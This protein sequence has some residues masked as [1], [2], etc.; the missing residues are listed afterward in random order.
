MLQTV[1]KVRGIR[2]GFFA[3]KEAKSQYFSGLL[4]SF[5]V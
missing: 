5:L 3:T 1:D 2:L 4:A